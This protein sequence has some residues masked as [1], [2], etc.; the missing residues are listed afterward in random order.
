MP[1]EQQFPPA[2]G[3]L[4]LLAADSQGWFGWR[5]S[6][7]T[8]SAARTRSLGASSISSPRRPPLQK[9]VAKPSAAESI[10]IGMRLRW[11]SGE[12]PPTTYPGGPLGGFRAGHPSLPAAGGRGQRGQAKADQ[13]P[14]HRSGRR[15]AGRSARRASTG[16]ST[17]RL[18][19][20]WARRLSSRGQARR[21]G[22]PDPAS[23]VGSRGP[24]GR[25]ST[26]GSTS[27]P[28]RPGP[29]RRPGTDGFA[30]PPRADGSWRRPGIRGTWRSGSVPES[31]HWPAARS[32]SCRTS[33]RAQ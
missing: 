17:T 7:T 20:G 26:G 18:S 8:A 9:T 19:R 33:P 32:S 10:T 11:P 14:A 12:M 15:P 24:A 5:M 29:A 21:L 28:G 22:S 25:A 23:L 6:A 30:R 27:R 31:W 2:D 16:G 13:Q 3:L 4:I 1:E